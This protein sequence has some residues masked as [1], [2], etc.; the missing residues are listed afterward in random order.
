MG[1]CWSALSVFRSCWD[2]AGV[3]F[4]VRERKPFSL[5]KLREEGTIDFFS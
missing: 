1:N 3:I 2:E 5:G 4:S